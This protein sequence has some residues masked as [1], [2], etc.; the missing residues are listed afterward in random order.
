MP[1]SN[2]FRRSFPGF[3]FVEMVI[4]FTLFTM[5]MTV[6]SSVFIT[7]SKNYNFFSGYLN[8]LSNLRFV[9]ERT[10]RE[11][12]EG[13]D[14][15]I[16]AGN[17]FTFINKDALLITYYLDPDGRIYR[18]AQGTILPITDERLRVEKFEPILACPN[19]SGCQP[20]VTFILKLAP[21]TAAQ[22]QF[23]FT[24]QFSVT[25]RRLAI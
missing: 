22:P 1:G 14:Y 12:K 20:T 9:L 10:S 8:G 3:T 5:L 11:V 17:Q 21:R 16:S 7:V 23:G 18:E 15:A 4:S 6:A 13:Y 24:L 2:Q 19:G 25:Q